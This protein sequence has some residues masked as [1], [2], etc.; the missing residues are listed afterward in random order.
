MG[1]KCPF[2]A[3]GETVE[4]VTQAALEHVREKHV[5]DFNLINSPAQIKEMEKALAR[6]TRI[7]AG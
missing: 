1:L 7:V 5:E 4:E 6:S 3:K 2:I